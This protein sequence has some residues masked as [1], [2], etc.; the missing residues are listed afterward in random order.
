ME[1]LFVPYNVA[2]QLKALG[3][4]P[5]FIG[6]YI[7][8][9]DEV[10][11]TDDPKEH[12]YLEDSAITWDEAFRLFREK[13]KLVVDQERDGGYWIFKIMD[14]YDENEQGSIEIEGERSYEDVYEQAQLESLK[15]LIQIVKESKS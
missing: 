15:K 3:L 11:I 7:S 13:Y 2:L 14:L 8:K 12:Y 4:I 6:V 1:K 5:V 10:K 9:T